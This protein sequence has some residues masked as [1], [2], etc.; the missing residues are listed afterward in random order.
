MASGEHQNIDDI[1]RTAASEC[2][3]AGEPVLVPWRI[4]ASQDH[5]HEGLAVCGCGFTPDEPKDETR[6]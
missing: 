4:E 3:K 6:L 5:L 1:I 2:A